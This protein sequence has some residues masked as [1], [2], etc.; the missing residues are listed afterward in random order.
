MQFVDVTVK[1]ALGFASC[2]YLTVTGTIIFELYSNVCDYLYKF[3]KISPTKFVLT[4]QYSFMFEYVSN[5]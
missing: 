5:F 1:I 2:N 3:T 4:R